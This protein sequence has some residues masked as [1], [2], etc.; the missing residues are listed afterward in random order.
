MT[1]CRDNH[2]LGIIQK[3][4]TIIIAHRHQEEK[5]LPDYDDLHFSLSE[6]KKFY[7]AL[8]SLDKFKQ[9][10]QEK[11]G[12]ISVSVLEIN[13]SPERKKWIGLCGENI[14]LLIAELEQKCFSKQNKS[15]KR[16][17]GK[18]I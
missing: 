11:T 14:A 1:R 18:Q 2:F 17:D 12:S 13:I 8:K 4:K 9:I 15:V 6:A 7:Y 16:N 5:D 3:G 10:I